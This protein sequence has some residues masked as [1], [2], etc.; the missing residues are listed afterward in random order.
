MFAELTFR[1]EVGPIVDGDLVSARW[2]GRGRTHDGDTSFFGSGIRGDH[3]VKYWPASSA[4][5]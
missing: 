3:F 4:G 5:S 2:T 1:I